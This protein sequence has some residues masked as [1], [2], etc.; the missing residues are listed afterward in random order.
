MQR[1]GSRDGAGTHGVGTLVY[2]RYAAGRRPA[3]VLSQR[4]PRAPLTPT[5]DPAALRAAAYRATP[6]NRTTL[7][8]VHRSEMRYRMDQQTLRS[9]HPMVVF[10]AF[11]STYPMQ[12]PAT[13]Y[14]KGVTFNR[15]PRNRPTKSRSSLSASSSTRVAAP[16]SNVSSRVCLRLDSQAEGAGIEALAFLDCLG[17]KRVP[18]SGS[19]AAQPNPLVSHSRADIKCQQL[20]DLCL[21]VSEPYQT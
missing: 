12:R 5:P 15:Q 4:T 10:L 1:E 20:A 11:R 17:R 2:P 6:G 19:Q 13:N 14:E 16:A 3:P 7:E 8:V 18:H 9:N 21:D